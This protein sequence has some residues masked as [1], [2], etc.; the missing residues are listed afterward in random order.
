MAVVKTIVVLISMVQPVANMM[1]AH[2]YTFRGMGVEEEENLTS[3][4]SKTDGASIDPI[5]SLIEKES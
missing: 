1:L 3:Y 5:K 2:H 4:Q